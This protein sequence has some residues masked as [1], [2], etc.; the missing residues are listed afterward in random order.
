MLTIWKY[1]LDIAMV[2]ALSKD[3]KV[4][5]EDGGCLLCVIAMPKSARIMSLQTFRYLALRGPHS[6]TCLWALVD[7]EQPKVERAFVIVPTGGAFGRHERHLRLRPG[8]LSG[9]ALIGA[10]DLGY[11]DTF[12][13]WNSEPPP[14]PLST[15]E[16]LAVRSNLPNPLVFH[17][18]AYFEGSEGEREALEGRRR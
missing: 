1:P 8:A 11:V 13:V 18:W 3:G 14:N 5:E 7:P 4:T 15:V 10:P 9:L 6:I 17:L 2:G 16:E 12:Q